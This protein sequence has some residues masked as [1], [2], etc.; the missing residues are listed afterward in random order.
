MVLAFTSRFMISLNSFLCVTTWG[1]SV[2]IFSILLSSCPSL[3]Y[4][5]DFFFVE[6]DNFVKNQLTVNLGV[7]FWILYSVPLICL[8][9]L[10]PIFSLVL[11]HVRLFAN[12]WTA[13]CQAS[14]SVIN[15]WTSLKLTSTELVMTSSHLI[16]FC[17]LLLPSI[18]PSIR[19]FSNDSVVRIS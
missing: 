3:I 14:L 2:F 13:A 15:S 10:T 7:Y 6:F 17:P 16:L 18:F 5:Q 4:W 1:G 19:V 12:P 11:S 8:S 9:I